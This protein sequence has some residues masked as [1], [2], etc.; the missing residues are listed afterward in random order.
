MRVV[1]PRLLQERKQHASKRQKKRYRKAMATV[2]MITIVGLYV[3]GSLLVPVP[4]IQAETTAVKI[5]TA[6]PVSILWPETG[7]AAVGAVGYGLLAEHGDQKPVPVASV[8][9]VLTAIAVLKAKPLQ[10]GEQGPSI[11]FTAADEATYHEYLAEGQSVVK[12]EAGAQMTQYE[13]LQA[14]MLPSANNMAEILARWAF[15]SVEDYTK[16][17]TAFTKSLGLQNTTI[18]DASGYDPGTVSTAADLT[19]LAE[20]AM[21]NPVLAEIAA[22]PEADLPVAGTVYNSNSYL[23]QDGLVG[24]KTGTTDEAGGCFMFAAKRQIE[25]GQS[26]VVVGVVIGADT[27]GEAME[28][29]MSII[30]DTYKGFTVIEPVKSGQ[31]VGTLQ[32]SGGKQSNIQ[33]LQ[34]IK[35]VTWAD[36]KVEL[37]TEL[38]SLGRSVAAKD[39]VGK[40]EVRVGN[41]SQSATLVSEQQLAQNSLWW[42]LTHAGGYL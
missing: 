38:Q 11:T 28:Q 10:I 34:G 29:S 18:A 35:I 25:N 13:A 9:K 27:R 36:T 12:V 6:P 14:L 1:D 17:M 15:G 19:K 2:L 42:R 8:A 26:V 16:Y 41:V 40:V 32:Q 3:V 7:Q 24:L 30:N 23:G 37:K 5:D 4:Y 21:N 31:V 33:V 39:A 22:Q 20:I